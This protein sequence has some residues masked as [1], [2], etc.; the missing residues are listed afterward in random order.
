MDLLVIP[1]RVTVGRAFKDGEVEFKLRRDSDSANISTDKI[2]KT[3]KKAIEKD[4]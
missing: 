1:F 3:I 4:L 2:V